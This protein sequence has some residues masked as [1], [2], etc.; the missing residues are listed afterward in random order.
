MSDKAT[1]HGLDAAYDTMK[2]I[3]TLC[4]GV[5]ALSVTFAGAFVPDGDD[6]TVPGQLVAAWGLLVLALFFSLWALLAITGSLNLVDQDPTKNDAMTSN[7]RIPS[8]LAL[9]T[10]FAAIGL[11]AYAGWVIA[12]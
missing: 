2:H 1:T 4:T 5:I 7:V 10:F 12:G 8:G 11:T 9:L 6:L 3:T